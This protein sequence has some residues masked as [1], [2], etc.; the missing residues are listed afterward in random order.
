MCEEGE[1]NDFI[2]WFSTAC[3]KYSGKESKRIGMIYWSIWNNRNEIVWNQKGNEFAEVVALAFLSLEQWQAAQDRSFDKFMG[4]MTRADDMEQWR[5][6]NEGISKVNTD[7]ATFENSSSY[8]YS[9]LA[10]DHK[11]ELIEV[12]AT[13]KQGSIDPAIAEAISVREALSWI[14]EKAWQLV[15]VESDCLVIIQAIRQT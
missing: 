3:Q 11:G 14:K 9:R 10:R 7:A 12:L 6:P 4:F 13:C 8:S 1:Y 5:C 2:E 15:V